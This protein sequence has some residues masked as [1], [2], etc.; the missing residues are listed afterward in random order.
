MDLIELS[1]QVFAQE[2]KHIIP[3]L[4]ISALAFVLCLIAFFIGFFVASK[5]F[6]KSNM[7]ALVKSHI[8][9]LALKLRDTT[10]E[11]DRLLE[12]SN[13][14]KVRLKNIA[15]LVALDFGLNEVKTV[16]LGKFK[17]PIE[18]DPTLPENTIIIKSS[19]I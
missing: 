18:L 4:I 7:P 17:I 2:L 14:F 6:S 5:K 15:A 1:R 8:N 10:V 13:C 11:R 3:I 12:Q 16:K 9:Y 19:N